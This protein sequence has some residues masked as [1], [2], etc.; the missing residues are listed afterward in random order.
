MAK[1]VRNY[2][3]ISQHYKW[4]LDKVFNQMNY[5]TVIITEDDLDLSNDFF[6]YFSAT[7][8]L[9][10]EDPS[11]WTD[12]FPGLGWMMTSKLW[13]ELSSNWPNIYWD[14]WM[15]QTDVRKD[16]VCIRP[17][18]SRTLHNMQVAGK[19]SSN[20]LFKNYLMSIRLPTE[21]VEF[22]LLDLDRLKKENF[23]VQ[24]GKMV[25]E[26]KEI[27][28]AE[29]L[30]KQPKGKLSAESAYRIVYKDPREYRR[31]ANQFKLMTDFRM[32]VP[33]TA[34]FGVVTFMHNN[35]RFY[36]VHANLK[37]EEGCAA[38]NS[39]SKIYDVE[40]E[41]MSRYLDF[42]EV[43]CKPSRW[44]GKCDPKDAAMIDW[45]DKKRLRKRLES[46]GELKAF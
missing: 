3:Y 4:S 25:T 16:R 7:Q 39:S 46:W 13:A 33:R 35:I 45:F 17:E 21:S 22:S 30:A 2:F 5:K 41:K 24:F 32:G 29:L 8:R 10:Y 11:I 40:W 26:A 15:R 37:L 9:L 43:Y 44:K 27:S 14:D 19:G 12:F 42:A 1:S 20:G 28:V 18:I 36:L 34:Y 6:S 23:D 38:F 31:I